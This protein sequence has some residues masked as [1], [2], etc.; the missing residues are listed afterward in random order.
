MPRWVPRIENTGTL[1]LI[2]DTVAYN[3]ATALGGGAGL[4]AV[5]GTVTLFN[6]IFAMNTD[7]TATGAALDDISGV[8]SSSSA[9]N[10]IDGASS[11]GGLANASNGNVVGVAAGLA[12]GLADNGGST[13]T[14]ALLP[15]SPA[16]NAGAAAIP[17]RT[18]CQVPISAARFATP[19]I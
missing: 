13:Q 1:T 15:G 14:I 10:V 9:N 8:L 17:G 11:A 12:A 7:G 5:S 4:D 6:S 16:I 19:P 2:N 3:T 18:L